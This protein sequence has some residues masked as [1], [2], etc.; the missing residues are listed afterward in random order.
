ML[1]TIKQIR[2]IG[3]SLGIIIDKAILNSAGIVSNDVVEISCVDD[4]IIIKKI[5]RGQ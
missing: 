4:S 2:Q 5:K 1:R 3:N